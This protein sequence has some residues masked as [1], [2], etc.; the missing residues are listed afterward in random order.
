V[1][2]LNARGQDRSDRGGA[3]DHDR[4]QHPTKLVLRSFLDLS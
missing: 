2:S 1:V 3:A 4:F